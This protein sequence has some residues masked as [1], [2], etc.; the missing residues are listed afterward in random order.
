MFGAGGG[1]EADGHFPAEEARFIFRFHRRPIL[2]PQTAV[3]VVCAEGWPPWAVTGQRCKATV[4]GQVVPL[5]TW[6]GE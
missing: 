4:T 1:A 2:V 3:K 6:E 5:A